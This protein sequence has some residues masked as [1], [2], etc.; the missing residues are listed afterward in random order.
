MRKILLLAGALLA[1]TVSC[2]K[3]EDP[4]TGKECVT[5]AATQITQVSATLNGYFLPKE[6]EETQSFFY[7]IVSKD[8]KQLDVKFI[9]N[10]ENEDAVWI[11]GPNEEEESIP[12]QNHQVHYNCEGRFT[13]GTTFYFRGL[14]YRVTETGENAREEFVQADNICS[15]TT[16]S[17]NEGKTVVTTQDVTGAG[18]FTATL[19]ATL[20]S[21]AGKDVYRKG[22]FLYGTAGSTLEQLKTSGTKAEA[23]FSE[24]GAS[25]SAAIE[26]LTYSTTYSYVAYAYLL[27]ESTL[28]YGE[29]KQFT[30]AD[31]NLQVTTL[32]AEAGPVKATLSA[33]FSP[34]AD[35]LG[36]VDAW[37]L[38]GPEGATLEALKAE[39]L[40]VSATKFTKD[41]RFS[42]VTPL[43]SLNTPYSFVGAVLVKGKEAYGQVQSFSTTAREVPEGAVE[44]GL[45]VLWAS[46]NVGA[47]S[48]SDY[49]DFYAWGE[50]ETKEKYDISTYKWC[51][52]GRDKVNG[53]TK[54]NQ[55]EI[56]GPVVDNKTVLDPEDD[57]ATVHWGAPW[58]MAMAAEWQ[59]LIDKCDWEET[60]QDGRTGYLAT[61]RITGNSIFLVTIS[62]RGSSPIT[63][64]EKAYYYTKE[65]TSSGFVCKTFR[66][67]DG[68]ITIDGFWRELGTV[69]RPVRE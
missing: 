7:F 27:D 37:F 48:P 35:G 30:T 50:V 17:L 24:D 38:V 62:Y 58:R 10:N 39:G 66:I 19:S 64:T 23:S 29:V 26:G 12:D 22:G 31:F 36:Y 45:S 14:I 63:N 3:T 40:K 53:Y 9:I 20:T 33:S 49:G 21:D 44:M 51:N 56:L 28:Q 67:A 6:T 69:I 54:Y 47:D 2:N 52:G 46:R 65:M 57:A 13:P 68:A 4:F 43:L 32:E 41:Q 1:L 42:A 60:Q 61:S 16:L 59:E 15:F 8:P 18:P 5:L 25:F 11:I 34:S 55:T